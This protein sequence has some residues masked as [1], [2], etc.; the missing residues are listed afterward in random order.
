MR[1]E[2]VESYTLN[3]EPLRMVSLQML[4]NRSTKTHDLGDDTEQGYF[5][6][7]LITSTCLR[8]NAAICKQSPR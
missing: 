1:S 7:F 8:I 4:V 3:T 6:L 5:W 2:Y